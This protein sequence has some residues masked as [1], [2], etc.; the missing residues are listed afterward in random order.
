MNHQDKQDLK[1]IIYRLDE[2]DK[3]REELAAST[4][5]SIEA[6]YGAIADHSAE[7]KNSFRFIKENLFDPDKGLWAETKANTSFRINIVR[8]LWF[9][10]PATVATTLKLFY[11][12][13]KNGLR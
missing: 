2:Q 11:E 8:T 1:L 4:R 9:V 6:I 12:T 10:V 13:I 5:Q 3:K 7:S